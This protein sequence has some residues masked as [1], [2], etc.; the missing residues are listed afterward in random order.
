MSSQE[1]KQQRQRETQ[2]TN[3][4]EN[5]RRGKTKWLACQLSLRQSMYEK[6]KKGERKRRRTVSMLG[7]KEM[8]MEM[9]RQISP[10]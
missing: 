6:R 8:A 2:K 10:S 3:K 9:E 5:I 7:V 4:N 1:E